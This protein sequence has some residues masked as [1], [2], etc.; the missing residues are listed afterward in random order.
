MYTDDIR[1]G[2]WSDPIYFDT[3]GFDHDLFFDDDGSV[4]LGW[5]KPKVFPTD[6]VECFT[7]K[8]DLATGKTT[9]TPQLLVNVTVLWPEGSHVYKINGT[10]YL[11]TAAGGTSG[12]SH[13]ELSY[14]SNVSPFGPWTANPSNPVLKATSG[15]TITRT[16]HA[17]M[18]QDKNG[19]WW[20]VFLGVRLQGS[21]A[22]LGKQL[23]TKRSDTR[24]S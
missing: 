19:N 4:Y 23:Y 1:S 16:G 3:P 9:T 7:S 22:Q 10:Y 13:Q 5:T 12:N 21:I 17:D 8:I 15:S 11:N 6:W 24:F 20:A 2:T 18:V 14:R